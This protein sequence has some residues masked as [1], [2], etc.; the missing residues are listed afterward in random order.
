MT[1][2]CN[3]DS[4]ISKKLKELRSKGET[5]LV[6]YSMTGFPTQ[7]ESADVVSGMIRGGADIIEMGFPFS[8]PLADGPAIQEAGTTALDCGTTF[9]KFLKLSRRARKENP[10]TPLILMTYSNI[11]YS[12]GY[13]NAARQIADAGIDGLILPDMPADEAGEYTKS[14]RS[15]GLDTIFL[16]SPNTADAR[17]RDMV[18][19]SSGF[20]YL[21]AVYGTTGVRKAAAA[22][23]GT[24][25]GRYTKAAGAK[26]TD[27]ARIPQYTIDA[28]HRAKRAAAGRLAVGVGF[29]VSSPADVAA[30]AEAGA[31]AVIVGSAYTGV[32]KKASK[33]GSIESDVAS[34]TRR[35]KSA[36]L[37]DSG[38]RRK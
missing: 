37:S 19:I 16:A 25:K 32:I 22:P 34:F 14:A 23:Y 12:R 29:G 9:E 8:D 15:C 10:D 21:V 24:K 13:Q 5:A 30:Y 27:I 26:G 36:T 18:S 31:D 38:R 7:R 28:I 20:L 6:T 11:I 17:L 3:A 33:S 35:L 4:R 1:D 2:I